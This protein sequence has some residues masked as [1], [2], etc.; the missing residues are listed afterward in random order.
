MAAITDEAYLETQ[1]AIQMVSGLLVGPLFADIDGLIDRADEALAL[2]PILHPSEFQ[3]AA[4]KLQT[5]IA[6]ARALRTARN[7]IAK[8]SGI[9][10]DH[11]PSLAEGGE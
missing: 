7:L 5:V 2:G 3:R 8:A 1:R 11:V 10:L 4:G 6:S 9:E